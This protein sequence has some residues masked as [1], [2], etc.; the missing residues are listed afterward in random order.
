MTEVHTN[1]SSIGLD[2]ILLEA[3]IEGEPLCMVYC[4]SRRTSEAES[5]YHSSKLEL[6][7][8]V[9]T[10]NK[11][12]QFLLG[13]WSTVYTYCQALVYLNS[14]KSL[15]SQIARWHDSLQDFDY[16]ISTGQGL[17]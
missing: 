13:I 5:R 10:I 4:A 7:C 9:W 14:N 2:F 6:L 17:V 11:L 15:S 16:T 12:R 1:V 8:I 3:A